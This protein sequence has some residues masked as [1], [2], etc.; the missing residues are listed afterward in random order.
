VTDIRHRTLVRLLLIYL[1]LAAVAVMAGKV[2]VKFVY[3]GF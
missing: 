2:A 1:K 3:G